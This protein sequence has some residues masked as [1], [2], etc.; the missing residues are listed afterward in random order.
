MLES[1]YNNVAG[2]SLQLYLKE[3]PWQRCF[4]VSF[5]KFFGTPF[6]REFQRMNASVHY[7]LLKVPLITITCDYL[8]ATLIC[9]FH[10]KEFTSQIKLV[11]L[12]FVLLRDLQ[13]IWSCKPWQSQLLQIKSSQIRSNRVSIKG[14]DFD[15][16]AD[17]KKA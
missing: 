6:F 1:L 12:C 16:D 2:L 4:P 7:F 13:I 9:H 10:I 3:T 8:R 14:K 11:Y 5:A 15:T 17:I